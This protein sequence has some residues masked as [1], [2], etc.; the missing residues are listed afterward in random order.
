MEKQIE[1]IL[2][3]MAMKEEAE[4]VI[5]NLGLKPID[6]SEYNLDESLKLSVYS[7]VSSRSKTPNIFLI[8]NGVRRVNDHP[9]AKGELVYVNAVGTI[10]AVL[11]AW[12]GMKAFNPDVVITAGTAGGVKANGAEIGDV[13][14]SSD[15]LRFHDRRISFGDYLYYGIGSYP[16]LECRSLLAKYP[17]KFKFGVVSTGNSLDNMEPAERFQFYSN[18]AT[19]KDMEAAA[20]GE[21]AQLKGIPVVAVKSITDLIDKFKGS[22]EV[23]NKPKE[24]L[25]SAEEYEDTAMQFLK[26]LMLATERLGE[27]I[28]LVVEHL[29]GKFPS[30]C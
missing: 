6:K 18:K 19:V 13:Y 7:C 16:C 29:L 9:N 25:K 14:I 8:Q 24:L 17:D 26:N 11:A 10:S 12:E 22:D 2:I 23:A 20:I 27:T 15:R 1:K 5:K 4:P 3:I 30:Q 28:P 21:I